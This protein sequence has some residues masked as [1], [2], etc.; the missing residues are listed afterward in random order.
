MY[1]SGGSIG[2]SLL[3]IAM[4]LHELMLFGRSIGSNSLKIAMDL[5]DCACRLGGSSG[6]NPLNIAMDSYDFIS[7]GRSIGSISL[8]IAMG[9]HGLMLF[10]KVHRPRL[11][12][13]IRNGPSGPIWPVWA[14]NTIR[15]LYARSILDSEPCQTLA[16]VVTT[17]RN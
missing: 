16:P 5:H 7:W 12:D 4:D 6:S 3:K 14:P 10:G 17:K 11:P 15:G 13:F 9:S 2:S 1:S 8:K